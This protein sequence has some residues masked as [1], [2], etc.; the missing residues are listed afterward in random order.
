MVTWLCKRLIKDYQEVEDPGVRQSYGIL[1][2]AVGI[3]LNA[4]LFAGKFLAGFFSHSVAITADA[5]NNLSDA[6]SSVVTLVG[7]RMAGQKPDPHH[8]FGHGRI[9][10]ISGLI[11]AFIILMMGLELFKSSVDKILHPEAVEATPLVIGILVVSICVKIYMSIYNRRI[12]KLIGSTAM[13]AA[14]KDSL[15]DTLAT[16]AVLGT[17]LLAKFTGLQIDGYCGVLVSFFVFTAGISAARETINPLLGQ[18]PE[19]EF[20]RQIQE[21]MMSYREQG[22]LDIHDLVVHNYGPGRVMMSVHAEVPANSSMVEMHDLIDT[23]EHRLKREMGCEAVIH[24][25]P[26]SVDDER[27]KELKEQVRE[28]VKGMEGNIQ[29]HDFRVVDGPSHTNIIFDVVVPFAYSM[30]DRQVIEYIQD[31]VKKLSGNYNVVIDVDKGGN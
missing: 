22:I 1:C 3:F 20:V 25:D 24:M 28:I 26:V 13:D 18:P 2:G 7:F 9:E 5:F 31:Q 27:T 8:P 4:L 23:V 15:S 10:Y 21:I 19:P 16:S 17:T 14:S 29:F 11:V 6:G 12:G 30:S